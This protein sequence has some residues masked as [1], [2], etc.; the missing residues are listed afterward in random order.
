VVESTQDGEGEDLATI[1]IWW[2]R[3]TILFWKLLSDAL[4]RPD[5]IEGL[6]RGMKDTIQLLLL[7]EEQVIETLSSYPS[8]IAFTERISPWCVIRRGEHL[9]AARVCDSSK[10]GS[11]RAVMITDELLRRLP[12]GRCLPQRYGRAR[13]WEESSSPRRREP[14]AISVH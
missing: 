5:S 13:R 3:L 12:I 10:T 1:V 7:K 9:D 2:T 8:Q 14:S 11:K 6:D 4:M